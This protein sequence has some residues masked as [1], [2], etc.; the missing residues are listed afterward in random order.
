[1][2]ALDLDRIISSLG[3]NDITLNLKIK[4]DKVCEIKP[5]GK[6]IDMEILEPEILKNF[7]KGLK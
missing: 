4:G 3:N 5:N 7:L 6:E 1:M 2:I